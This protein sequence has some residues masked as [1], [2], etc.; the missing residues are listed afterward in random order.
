MWKNVYSRVTELEVAAELTNKLRYNVRNNSLKH[1]KMG[2]ACMHNQINPSA[3]Q[4]TQSPL[5]FCHSKKKVS[6]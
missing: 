4:N 6:T 5:C 3:C 2:Y 1:T